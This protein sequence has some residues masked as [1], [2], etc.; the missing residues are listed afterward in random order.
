M[1]FT[2]F[3]EPVRIG[4]NLNILRR[5]TRIENYSSFIIN[6]NNT[7]NTSNTNN[8]N[9]TSNTSNTS[10]NSNENVNIES[11]SDDDDD[12]RLCSICQQ[13]YNSTD[14]LRIIN[15]C[16]HYYH[17]HCLDQ[18]LENNTK[19]PECQHDLR[20]SRPLATSTPAPITNN[21][22][23]NDIPD[24][25]NDTTNPTTNPITSYQSPENILTF[26]LSNSSSQPP[27]QPPTQIPA[28]PSISR[29]QRLNNFFQD[30]LNENPTEINERV[31]DVE[32]YMHSPLYTQP[33]RQPTRQPPTNQSNT[34][35]S[36]HSIFSNLLNTPSTNT[37]PQQPTRRTITTPLQPRTERETVNNMLEQY[38]SLNRIQSQLERI[39]NLRTEELRNMRRQP[40]QPRQTH[41]IPRRAPPPPSPPSQQSIREARGA[42]GVLEARQFRQTPQQ[43]QILR[44]NYEEEDTTDTTNEEDIS[45]DINFDREIQ[46]L[47]EKVKTLEKNEKTN[48]IQLRKLN[49]ANQNN[50]EK[51]KNLDIHINDITTELKEIKEIK[52]KLKSQP[53]LNNND[54]NSNDNNNL[55]LNITDLTEKE[56]VKLIKKKEKSHS[57]FKFWKK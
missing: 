43:I 25:I 55:K 45:I 20:E 50:N 53:N 35:L 3:F 7:S 29:N 8:T 5:T 31:I 18:W 37:T 47:N 41:Q 56:E 16:S 46:L 51:I 11:E 2:N 39:L 17:Q 10:N 30:I 44:E 4:C 6:T 23:P 52:D 19:C 34:P 36:E 22:I 33:P 28:Q 15:H 27:R 24:L 32:Y 49:I 54:D 42:R 14:I 48:K 21:N 12:D 57:R 40:R 26:L 38:N 9:N 1:N 13:N